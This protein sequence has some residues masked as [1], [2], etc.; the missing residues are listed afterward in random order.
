MW[1]FSHE[2]QVG[3]RVLSY[4]KEKREYIIG[5]VTQSHFY[6]ETIGNPDYPN[7][8]KVNWETQTVERD[9]LSQAA[10]NSLG[11]CIDSIP[12]RSMGV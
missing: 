4:S 11:S 8:L 7:T 1:R 12:C 9:L 6:D 10:K 3:D 2:I 5:T